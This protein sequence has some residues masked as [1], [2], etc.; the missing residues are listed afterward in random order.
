MI[1]RTEAVI[2]S[3][4]DYGDSSKIIRAFTK[5]HG[6][7]SFIAKGAKNAKNRFGSALLP[8]S[9]SEIIFNFRDGKDL[10]VLSSAEVIA[11]PVALNK[12]INR[13]S[14]GLSANELVLQT[15]HH[16]YP[17]ESVYEVLNEA[18]TGLNKP[19][20]GPQRL[21]VRFLTEY[22]E[23]LGYDLQFTW[24]HASE[25]VYEP[26]RSVN[27]RLS[28]CRLSIADRFFGSLSVEME[29]SAL[30]TIKHIKEKDVAG[31]IEG[32]N[33]RQILNFFTRYFS[34]HF[35]KNIKF[36]SLEFLGTS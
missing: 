20:E 34:Y 36:R 25:A 22:A 19:E 10:L 6:L 11:V 5:S 16:H 18:L 1:I 13:L 9:V 21:F 2:L 7:L 17:N 26:G 3:S 14:I 33:F 4:I 27:V 29:I 32:R 24:L 23:A 35:D 12:D 28:D 8:M 30:L 15:Q 31:E